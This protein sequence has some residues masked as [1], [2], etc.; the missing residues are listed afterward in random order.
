RDHGSAHAPAPEQDCGDRYVS[1]AGGHAL[2]DRA[3]DSYREEGSRVSGEQPAQVNRAAAPPADVDSADPRGPRILPRRAQLKPP[4][5]AVQ[6]PADGRK[7]Q[8][9]RIE[10]P[11]LV[12]QRAAD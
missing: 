10:R 7:Q 12:K 9:Y 4:A 8:V 3:D 6:T 2:A 11:G 5:R 1:A